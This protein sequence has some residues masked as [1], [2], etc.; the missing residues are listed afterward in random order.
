MPSASLDMPHVKSCGSVQSKMQSTCIL[1]NVIMVA[2]SRHSPFAIHPRCYAFSTVLCVIL[3]CAQPTKTVTR[4]S[5]VSAPTLRTA[6]AAPTAAARV[7][8]EPV[9]SPHDD[10]WVVVEDG[11]SYMKPAEQRTAATGTAN[12][13]QSS[14]SVVPSSQWSAQVEAESELPEGWQPFIDPNSGHT[15]YWN[16]QKQEATWERPKPVPRVLSQG[17]PPVPSTPPPSSAAG[18]AA[19]TASGAGGPRFC[20]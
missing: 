15:Y 16:E 18:A 8:A 7:V 1:A 5:I 10:N 6:A 19:A 17:P 3:A 4:P 20:C 11:Y 13:A 2:L 12:A 9:A 14:H